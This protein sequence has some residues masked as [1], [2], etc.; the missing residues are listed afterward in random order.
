MA[1]KVP[2]GPEKAKVPPPDQA[3]G[4]ETVKIKRPGKEAGESTLK[5]TPEMMKVLRRE[6]PKSGE[7]IKKL[8]EAMIDKG[9]VETG[10]KKGETLD[11]KELGDVTKKFIIEDAFD[12]NDGKPVDVMPRVEPDAAAKAGTKPVS[13]PDEWSA[14]TINKAIKQ[15]EDIRAIVKE[16]SYEEFKKLVSGGQYLATDEVRE[17]SPETQLKMSKNMHD[18]IVP[19]ISDLKSNPE[20]VL[21]LEVY[22]GRPH[23]ITKDIR[24]TLEQ[25]AVQGGKFREIYEA[26]Q[27]TME[28]RGRGR[29]QLFAEVGNSLSAEEKKR[30][31]IALSVLSERDREVLDDIQSE[32]GKIRE[33]FTMDDPELAI[34]KDGLKKSFK[35]WLQNIEQKFGDPELKK[36]AEKFKNQYIDNV[37]S[38]A[39]SDELPKGAN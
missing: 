39:Y 14:E 35:G 16:V 33:K 9:Q 4:S 6:K 26:G 19:V 13:Y 17:L 5:L 18:G 38:L 25:L 32:V 11:P 23:F 31:P 7:D 1:T 24:P 20:K 29:L 15:A 30:L 36:V 27:K 34:I 12:V 28:A 10:L 2:N 3:K 37:F 22:A 8:I 21:V